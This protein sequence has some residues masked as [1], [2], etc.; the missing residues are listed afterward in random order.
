MR[1]GGGPAAAVWAST[2]GLVLGP[3]KE[4][5]L[6]GFS[7]NHG[8]LV[9]PFLPFV[10]GCHACHLPSNSFHMNCVNNQLKAQRAL[11]RLAVLYPMHPLFP[12]PL[13]L[14][15]VLFTP[16]AIAW[17]ALKYQQFFPS[18]YWVPLGISRTICAET[19][20]NYTQSTAVNGLRSS[21]TINACYNHE[22]CIFTHANEAQKS[23][24]A[25]AQVLLGLAPSLLAN[26]GPQLAEVALLS[27]RRPVLSCLLS[28]G[29]GTIYPVRVFQYNDPNLLLRG[30]ELT[31]GRMGPQPPSRAMAISAGQ[32]LLAM[33][34]VVNTL[35]LLNKLG[36][37]AVEAFDCTSYFFPLV[38]WLIAV[39]IHLMAAVPFNAVQRGWLKRQNISAANTGRRVQG[40]ECS[41]TVRRAKTARGKQS[42]LVRV[43]NSALKYVK[44]AIRSEI[45]I[46]ANYPPPDKL[47]PPGWVVIC[48]CCCGALGFFHIVFGTMIFSSLLFITYVDAILCVSRLVISAA[49]CRLI[50]IME[51]GSMKSTQK[52]E[53]S[54]G[55]FAQEQTSR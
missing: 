29:A 12:L 54:D 40:S 9:L 33:G 1:S 6:I 7:V 30:D 11:Q 50:L 20:Q 3:Q 32:Y 53:S 43:W 2:E 52:F 35:T 16:P 36:T 18:H 23:I 42:M 27:S 5:S 44:H 55:L 48:N 22:T 8:L 51:F 10:Q 31:F 41:L 45:T 49:C 46:C 26:L 38:W 14:L 37:D 15:P 13:C 17:T 47:S 34:A 28:M 24:W 19:L 21:I 25:S 4:L 39:L